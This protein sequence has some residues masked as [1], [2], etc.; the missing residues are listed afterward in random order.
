[1]AAG[2]VTIATTHVRAGGKIVAVRRIT[3][4]AAGRLA[5]D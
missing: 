3:I 5:V 4:T 1:V 2:H